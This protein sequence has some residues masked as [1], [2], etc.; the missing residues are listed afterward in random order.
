MKYTKWICLLFLVLPLLLLSQTKGIINIQ[1]NSDLARNEVV[2]AVKWQ[3]VLERYPQIDT[4]NFVVIN[5]ST[6][7]QVPYQLERKGLAT[8]QNLLLQVS[9]K[10][11]STLSLLIKKGKPDVFQ[12]KTYA[13]YIPERLDDFAWENDRI[14]FRAYGKALEGSKDNAYGLDIW[15]KRTNKMILNERYKRGEYHTDHGDG[16]DYYKVGFTLGAGAMAPYVRDTVRYSANYHRW[17]ILDN[18]PLRSTFQ[19]E[20]DAWN[21]AGIKVKCTRTISLDAGSQFNRIENNYTYDENLA[22]PVAVGISKR[23]ENGVLL[24]NEQKG[25]LAYWEPK[26]GDDGTTGVATVLTT[27]VKNM[28]VDNDQ[29]LAVSE[30]KNNEP[31]VYYAGAAWDKAGKITNSTQWFSYVDNFAQELKNPLFVNVK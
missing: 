4:A 19:L 9:V 10:A 7:K 28:K 24:L 2:V 15:V 13:R 12:T 25:V 1:N 29:L 18:G 26:H 30:V 16:L 3:T 20:Y 5:S 21:A 22:L 23:P 14:A 31:I 17:K 6:N 8:I 27:V 11:Q